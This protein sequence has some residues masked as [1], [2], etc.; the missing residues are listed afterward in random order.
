MRVRFEGAAMNRLFSAFAQHFKDMFGTPVFTPGARVNRF[1]NGHLDRL[2]GHV[3]T[4]SSRGVLVEWP[5]VGTTW[6]TPT[7][8]CQQG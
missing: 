7:Q 5:R 2:D 4:Q 1:A 8:L 6:E 3:L